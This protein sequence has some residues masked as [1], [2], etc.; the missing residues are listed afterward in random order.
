MAGRSTKTTS[1]EGKPT[2]EPGSDQDGL[3]LGDLARGI[4]AKEIRPRVAEVRRLA[5]AVLARA[6]AG[7]KGKAGGKKKD[8][9]RPDKKGG[10]DKKVRKLAKIPGQKSKN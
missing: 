9:P 10:E 4:L 2:R 7:K 1:A 6:G 5:E 8:K 3:S